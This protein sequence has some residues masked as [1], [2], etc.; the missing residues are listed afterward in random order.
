[1]K[2]HL[3]SWNDFKSI[4]TKLIHKIKKKEKKRESESEREREGGRERDMEERR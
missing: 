4:M 2:A 3:K 1:M